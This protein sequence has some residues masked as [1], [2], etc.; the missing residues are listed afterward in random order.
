[1]CVGVE[2]YIKRASDHCIQIPVELRFG[3]KEKLRG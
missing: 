2:L 1:M 3:D